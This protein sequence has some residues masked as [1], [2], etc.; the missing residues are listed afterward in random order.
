MDHLESKLS[1]KTLTNVVNIEKYRFFI[2]FLCWCFLF[3]S[4]CCG[5]VLAAV[6]QKPI[7][8]YILSIQLTN[9]KD[10]CKCVSYI[11]KTDYQLVIMTI[12][13]CS[14]FS[15][16]YKWNCRNKCC[17]CCSAGCCSWCDLLHC[18][19]NKIKITTTTTTVSITYNY[20]TRFTEIYCAKRT[21]VN[22]FVLLLS[23]LFFI[24]V[25]L[26]LSL[27]LLG[28]AMPKQYKK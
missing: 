28:Q 21:V 6:L 19:K 26:F 22:T 8:N 1:L 12:F 5:A 20:L 11:S 15:S 27:P 3:S 7:F 2:S 10:G 23:F 14:R 24:F 25:L 9:V 13:I 4:Q 16:V 17:W 18:K